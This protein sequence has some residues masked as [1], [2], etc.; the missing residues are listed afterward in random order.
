MQWLRVMR[1]IGGWAWATALCLAGA[2][3]LVYRPMAAS[4]AL[5]IAAES[6]GLLVFWL[7]VA[8]PLCPK[9]V[10][11]VTNGIEAVAGAVFVVAFGWCIWLIL[12]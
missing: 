1:L 4:L 5:G 2:Y 3:L 11:L 8:D 12:L 6:A 10:R 7:L 9:R